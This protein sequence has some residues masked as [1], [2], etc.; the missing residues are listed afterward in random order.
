MHPVPSL[1]LDFPA[2]VARRPGGRGIGCRQ[3]QEQMSAKELERLA[4]LQPIL[5][6]ADR[7]FWASPF[8]DRLKE[9]A[10]NF[11]I[12][13]G[14]DM[15]ERMMKE[16]ESPIERAFMSSFLAAIPGISSIHAWA[17]TGEFGAAA[18]HLAFLRRRYFHW[19]RPAAPTVTLF[20]QVE[21]LE[22]RVDFV[23][24]ASSE[25]S[26]ED[27]RFVALIVECDGHDFHERTKEQARRDREK[28]RRL[29]RI[30]YP[31]MRFTGQEIY[32]SA[33]KCMR[34]ALTLLYERFDAEFHFCSGSDVE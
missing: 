24:V 27:G 7:E 9:E 25:I 12:R 1:T 22:Y 10:E 5:E 33:S 3:G 29:Q 15:V 31:V 20:H 17:D 34:E 2:A 6:Q 21:I 13:R 30:G 14:I 19:L 32:E 8:M 18:E 28:D 26:L 11:A 16:L 23:A 4:Q